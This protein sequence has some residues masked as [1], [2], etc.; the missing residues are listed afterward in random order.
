MQLEES[1]QWGGNAEPQRRNAEM[2]FTDLA[3]FAPDFSCMIP[4]LSPH[5]T[6][7]DADVQ[8]KRYPER[9]PFDSLAAGIY[10]FHPMPKPLGLYQSLEQPRIVSRSWGTNHPLPTLRP[11]VRRSSVLVDD[12]LR[13][14]PSV[15]ERV[16]L[17]RNILKL[18]DL[19]AGSALNPPVAPFPRIRGSRLRAI[20]CN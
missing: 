9:W 2:C 12:K 19:P 18:Y 20:V 17:G 6:P 15:W 3:S 11:Q 5:S 1:P 16:Q 14:R 13:Q 4:R 8:T 10:A 7:T